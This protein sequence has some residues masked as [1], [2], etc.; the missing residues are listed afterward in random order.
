M[1]TR[2]IREFLDGSAARYVAISHSP[3]YTARETANSTQIPARK[4]AKT[5]VVVLDGNLALAV[6]PA[7]KDVNLELLRRRA[8]AHGARLADES[9]FADR[10]LGCKLGTAPPFGNLFGI[11][12]FIDPDLIRRREI[13]FA[14]GT[15]TDVIVMW[16]ADYQRLV[17]PTLVRMA[18]DADRLAVPVMS[19][20][21]GG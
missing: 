2:R 3:S 13:A 7:N 4:M 20:C 10:F 14:A 15:H 12:T 1:A 21:A 19:I 11:D 6:V 16:A 18:A 17:Q 8:N 5:V 9:E